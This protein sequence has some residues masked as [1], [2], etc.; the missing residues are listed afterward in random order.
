MQLAKPSDSCT[1]PMFQTCS[2]LE[3]EIN[4]PTKFQFYCYY[5][6]TC[7]GQPFCPS[8]GVLSYT[9][10]LV[11][12]CRFDDCLLPGAGWNC[13]SILPVA[14]PGIFFGVGRG[15]GSTNSFDDRGQ[16]GRGSGGGSPLVRGSGGS[17]NLV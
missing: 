4:R 17:C 9:S 12:F 3:N 6:S 11:H 10:A 5:D 7:F 2:F 8:S 15:D 13:S 1:M 14:Y 16:R